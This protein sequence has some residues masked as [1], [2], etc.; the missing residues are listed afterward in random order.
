MTRRNRNLLKLIPL[1][2][3]FAG[4]LYLLSLP[5]K[6]N[7]LV[8]PPGYSEMQAI[9]DSFDTTKE[10]IDS[11]K[12][13]KNEQVEFPDEVT[14]D[15]LPEFSISKI[16]NFDEVLAN[17]MGKQSE[18]KTNMEETVQTVN[19]SRANWVLPDEEGYLPTLAPIPK[20]NFHMLS[21]SDAVMPELPALLPLPDVTYPNLFSKLYLEKPELNF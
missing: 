11:A 9:R 21:M 7:V 15:D 5:S 10:A 20:L 3:L 2:A 1:C 4:G 6:P 13:D 8:E 18:I 14:A 19:Q 17:V 12:L 16:E